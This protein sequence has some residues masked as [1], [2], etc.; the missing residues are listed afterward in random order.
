MDNDW[1][2]WIEYRFRNT[3][4]GEVQTALAPRRGFDPSE[5]VIQARRAG[6][7]AGEWRDA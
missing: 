7:F 2:S 1:Q 6:R 3:I 4:T 5:W